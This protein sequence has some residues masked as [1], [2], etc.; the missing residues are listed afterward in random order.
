MNPDDLNRYVNLGP[1]TLREHYYSDK[2]LNVLWELKKKGY[3]EKTIEGYSKRLKM[4]SRYTDLD[5]RAC[6]Y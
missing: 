5:N 1:S 3:A 6:E 2:R 4:L